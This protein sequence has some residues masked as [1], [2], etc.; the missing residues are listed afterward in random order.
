MNV[1]FYRENCTY[2]DVTL[3]NPSYSKTDAEIEGIVLLS[4]ANA[5]DVSSTEPS[6]PYPL[7]KGESKTIRC[8]FNWGAYAGQ[9]LTVA[10]LIKDGSGGTMSYQTESVKLEILDVAYNTSVSINQISI[11]VRNPSRIPLDVSRV[12]VGTEEIPQNKIVVNSQNITFPYAFPQNDTRVFVC[13][14]KLWDS[15]TSIGVLGTTK[16]V[17]LET[18][19]GYEASLSEAFSDPVIMTLSSIT[20]PSSNTTQFILKSDPHSPHSVDISKITV[21]VGNQTYTVAS[22][23]TNATDY[24]LEKDTNVTIICAD[25]NFNWDN[26]KGQVITIRVYTTQGFVAKKEETIPST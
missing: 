15:E 1:T 22:G 5:D 11:T 13:N 21:T 6:I 17:I 26:W 10:V 8:N 25:S 4:D 19:Q 20:F 18:L 9:N 2:F 3:M 14:Y 16:G 24:V 7:G 23:N 12:L